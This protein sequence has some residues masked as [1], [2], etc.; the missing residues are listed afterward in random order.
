MRKGYKISVSL[1]KDLLKNTNRNNKKSKIKDKDSNID[2]ENL[3]KGIEILN[4]HKDGLEEERKTRIGKTLV[5][6]Q[7]E[8]IEKEIQ[9]EE[10]EKERK[11]GIRKLII[12]VILIF[13]VIVT[14]LFFEYGPI[15]GISLNKSKEISEDNRIDIVSTD[16]DIYM[17]YC[18]EL[19]IYSNRMLSTYNKYSKKTW[20]Y[21]IEETFTPN[22]YIHDK[23][24]AVANNS[25]GTIYLFENKKEILNKKVDGTISS[26]YMDENGNMAVEYS[27]TGYKKVIGVYNKK[28]KLM[29]N[30]YLTSDAIIDIELIDN[31][32]KL[33]VL[34]S[35]ASSFTI[36]TIVSIIDG[37][38]EE[39]NVEQILKL[40]NSLVYD[41]IMQG[42]NVILM[43]DDK[44]IS[45]NIDTKTVNDIKEYDSS[46]MLFIA[47]SNNY[48]TFVE[49]EL[50]DNEEY[51]IKNV[52]FD[53]TDIS[54]MYIDNLPKI[55]KNTGT[56]SYFIYQNK[57]QVINKWAVE[58]KNI[59]LSFPPKDI[60]VFNNEKSVDLIYTNKI[61][62]VNM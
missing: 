40:D 37:T 10:Q 14:Y 58:I 60:I 12:T 53:N 18:N 32:K 29:Y 48:Y 38:K 20:E 56:L 39:N 44:I 1:N 46:Q 34:E 5:E 23:Y 45:C 27:T 57:L 19:L 41:C 28:G 42:K 51:G 4:K 47:V 36:G 62:I 52:R 22:I 25:N 61:Y 35:D 6:V 33:L 50:G 59:E 31:A 13:L 43:L 3:S 17:N 9:E 16:E 55:M 54:S 8:I 21:K 24:M 30:T 15:V 7:E 49:K 26:V 2:E 11:N